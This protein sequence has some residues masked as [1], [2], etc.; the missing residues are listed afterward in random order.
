[1]GMMHNVTARLNSSFFFGVT[2]L[3]ILAGVNVFTSFF[4]E[5]P[6]F[7]KVNNI[8]VTD[9]V[10]NVRFGWDEARIM[11]DLDADLNG[12]YNWNVKL[13]FVYLE[14][15]Y[16]APGYPNNEV[17]IWDKIIER[18]QFNPETAKL[19]LKTEKAKYIMRTRSHDLRGAEVKARLVWEVTP[20]VGFVYK[21][22]GDEFKITFP[23]SY[24]R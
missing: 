23:T 20:I 7:A 11:F 1:M 3:G 17:I 16:E 15:K 21:M 24:T 22:Y 4:I 10:K 18:D 9:L 2:L 8:K 6:A 19:E 13:L 14:L 5:Q 12:V